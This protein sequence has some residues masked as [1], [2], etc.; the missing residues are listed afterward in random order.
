MVHNPSCFRRRI[1]E[2]LLLLI[3]AIESPGGNRKRVTNIIAQHIIRRIGILNREVTSKFQ[4]CVMDLT[5][6][7][8]ACNIFRDK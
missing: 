4:N 3:L 7:R 1:R 6:H 2:D 5:F 8:K